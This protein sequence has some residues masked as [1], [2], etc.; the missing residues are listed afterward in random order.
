MYERDAVLEV[1]GIHQIALAL[2]Q[3]DGTRVH[4]GGGLAG[5]GVAQHPAGVRLEDRDLT[6]DRSPDVHGGVG[7]EAGRREVSAGPAAQ[8]SVVDECAGHGLGVPHPDFCVSQRE[9]SGR[10]Q[11][12]RTQHV[13]IGRVNHHAFDRL[14]QE[15][16]GMMH[17]IGVERVVAGDEHHQSALAAPA[18]PPG[19]LPERRD[20]ARKARQH[21]SVQS[22]DVDT[23][24]ERIGRRHATQS[25]VGQRAFQCAAILGQVSRPVGGH[26]CGQL[27]VGLRQPR[28]G[29]QRRQLRAAS[30]PHERQSSCALGDQVGHH[31]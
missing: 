13:G 28:P 9:F 6:T 22:G 29:A 30:G 23:E 8:Q 15:S 18:R 31:A 24:F 27:R 11:Q 10:A 14:V 17:Q 16:S 19:L 12:L 7:I 20:R 26:R 2:V 1:Q 3:I 25:P 21:N 4:R 5:T